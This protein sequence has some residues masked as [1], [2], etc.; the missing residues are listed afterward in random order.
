MHFYK[1]DSWHLVEIALTLQ[2]TTGST[3]ILTKLSFLIHEHEVSLLLFVFFNL[4]QQCYTVLSVQF[5]YFLDET[6]S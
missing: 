4:F 3:G 5:L 2:I 1:K 6:Y